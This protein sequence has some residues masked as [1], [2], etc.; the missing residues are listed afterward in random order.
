MQNDSAGSA[1]AAMLQR[2]L[3]CAQN[4]EYARVF[5]A[6]NGEYARV[7]WAHKKSRARKAGTAE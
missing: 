4:G 1:G 5:C 3:F 7:F 6:Q 2:L